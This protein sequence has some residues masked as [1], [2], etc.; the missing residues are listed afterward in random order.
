[1]YRK[2]SIFYFIAL[3]FK[4]SFFKKYLN[5]QVR[6][7]KICIYNKLLYST[8]WGK[9]FQFIVFIFLENALNLWIFVYAPVP[10][11]KLQA[12]FF[13]NLFPPW[14]KRWRE[15]WFSLTKF[16]QKTGR[17]LWTL[18]YLYVVWFITFLNGIT[19]QSRK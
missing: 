16:N 11:S 18:G 2:V 15:L 17:W 1:M 6:I 19:L 14:R 7:N 5:F 9:F 13:E 4:C 8:M 12:G 3:L 10:Y